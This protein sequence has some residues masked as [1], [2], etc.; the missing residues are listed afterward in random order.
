LIIVAVLARRK[1]KSAQYRYL[2]HH[3]AELTA[4]LKTQRWLAR[5]TYFERYRRVHPLLVQAIR[6]QG[7]RA[8]RA[9]LADAR[10]V[11]VDKS[12]VPARGPSWPK[13]ARQA[14]R[15][16][17]GADVEGT[18]G[19]SEH[20]G[21][22][23]GYSYEV[24]VTANP[25]SLVFPL[26]ASGDTASRS[27]CVSFAAKIEQL[28]AQTRNVLADG[29]YDKN[30]YGDRLEYDARGRR[31]GRHFL[32]RPVNRH[33]PARRR[34]PPCLQNRQVQLARQRRDRRIAY[35]RSPR[36]RR[37]Y[38]RRTR[39]VEPFNEWFKHL[40][41]LHQHAWHRGIDNNRTQFLAAIFAYQL[42]VRYNHRRGRRNGK[43]KWLLDAL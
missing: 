32:C 9:G 37:L 3:R 7:L 12:L 34:G 17:R 31:T 8:L 6:I 15:K 13:A 42:L 14:G 41:E 18:W 2:T 43:I 27:E 28:P 24:V 10:T 29:G 1:S 25:Q 26:L 16:V 40:F 39:T 22:V 21:W 38:A 35:Y 19:Y 4:L 5:A 23:Y 20:H 11:A 33:R 30:E 36:G